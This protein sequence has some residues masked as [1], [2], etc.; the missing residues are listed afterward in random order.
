MNANPH[1]ISVSTIHCSVMECQLFKSASLLL[2]SFISNPNSRFLS[3]LFMLLSKYLVKK[4]WNQGD[5]IIQ[6]KSTIV[7]F[8]KIND[9]NPLISNYYE[10]SAFEL[11]YPS[12]YVEIRMKFSKDLYLPALHRRRKFIYFSKYKSDYG[13]T[14][15]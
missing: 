2:F 5:C 12:S 14:C 9:T 15:L 4:S 10:T 6:T 8:I 7:S 1:F 11:L 3:H 13:L